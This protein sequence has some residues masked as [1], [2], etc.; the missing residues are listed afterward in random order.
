MPPGEG[1]CVVLMLLTELTVNPR[2]SPFATLC[3]APCVACPER[4]AMH[5]LGAVPLIVVGEE[6]TCVTGGYCSGDSPGNTVVGLDSACA[7]V[8]GKVWAGLEGGV[9]IDDGGIT[10]RRSRRSPANRC[11]YVDIA[12]ALPVRWIG[13]EHSK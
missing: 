9:V 7:S 12:R 11:A 5:S 2:C 10:A 6:A 3:P 4:D 8:T 1:A 13:S